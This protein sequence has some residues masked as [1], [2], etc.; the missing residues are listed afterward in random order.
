[1]IQSS[2]SGGGFSIC[3]FSLARDRISKQFKCINVLTLP[4]HKFYYAT[5]QPILVVG[6][7][8]QHLFFALNTYYL[9]FPSVESR[10][11]SSVNA[12]HFGVYAKNFLQFLNSSMSA[13]MNF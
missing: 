6:M 2:H 3:H 10:K 5:P 7:L 1:M 11:V 9:T 8:E 13:E 12:Q 4:T